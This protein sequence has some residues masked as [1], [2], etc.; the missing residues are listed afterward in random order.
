MGLPKYKVSPSGEK[1]FVDKEIENIRPYIAF[2]LIKDVKFDGEKLKQIMD[3]Q[4]N[5]HWVI[6]RDRKKSSYWYS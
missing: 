6:G 3:F 1:V 4:E 5:L 2:A